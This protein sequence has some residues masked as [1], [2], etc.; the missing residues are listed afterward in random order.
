MSRPQTLSCRVWPLSLLF[1][2]STSVLG[3]E[4]G[5]IHGVL[6]LAGVADRPEA[7]AA[8]VG[9]EIAR[10]ASM[11]ERIDAHLPFVGLPLRIARGLIQ[12]ASPPVA[13]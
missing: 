6:H 7:I 8:F 9:A 13:R 3:P 10:G 5:S 12:P 4:F 11:R 2:A 1:A